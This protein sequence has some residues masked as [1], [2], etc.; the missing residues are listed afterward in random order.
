MSFSLDDRRTKRR[1]SSCVFPREGG[2]NLT[3][4]TWTESK[5]KFRVA[6]IGEKQCGKTAV[7]VRFLTGK[8][9]HEY[10]SGFDI[11]Y[12]HK[13]RFENSE[14][15]LEVVDSSTEDTDELVLSADA[16]VVVFSIENQASFKTMIDIVSHL[17][18]TNQT[19][20]VPTLIVGNKSDMWHYRMIRRSEAENA[21]KK[22]SCKYFEV[23]ARQDSD[24]VNRAFTYL[25]KYLY[26]S[27]IAIPISDIAIS[28]DE[29]SMTDLS[30]ADR[31]RRRRS[32]VLVR[33]LFRGLYGSPKKTRKTGRTDSFAQSRLSVISL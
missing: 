23:S 15:M 21:A 27:F 31:A 9:I 1:S 16:V 14:I 13:M 26:D 32:P 5:K 11:T 6:V 22:Y 4:P 24:S 2:W 28:S 19:H 33:K 12:H 8:F 30:F 29:G 7:V 3:P 10:V 20:L 18:D 17:H 25:A